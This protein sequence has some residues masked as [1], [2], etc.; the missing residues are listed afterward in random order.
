M[1]KL[2]T[3]SDIHQ[4]TDIS[5]P[6]GISVVSQS[7]LITNLLDRNPDAVIIAGDLQDYMWN[8]GTTPELE[9]SVKKSILDDPVLETLNKAKIPVYFVFGNTDIMDCEKE[10]ETTPLTDEIREWFSNEFTNFFDCH[11]KKFTIE[12]YTITG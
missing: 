5:P 2:L 4:G 6:S 1:T 3:I 11:M 9:N 7:K 10:T 12:E 8:D